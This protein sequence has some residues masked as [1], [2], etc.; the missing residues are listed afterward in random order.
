MDN[1]LRPSG[2][3]LLGDIPWGSHICQF[4]H[5]DADLLDLLVPWFQA[6][7]E[8]NECCMWVAS[9]PLSCAQA[10]SALRTVVPDLDARVRDGQ[11]LILPAEEWYLRDGRF[12]A[13]AVLD[14]W[15]AS[16]RDAQGRGYAG[17]RLSG[18]TFWLESPDWRD[19]TAYEAEV[20]AVISRNK[21]LALCTY[22]LEKCGA[23]EI[24]DVV[25]NHAVALIR[26]E[27][28]WEV[29]ES[30]ARRRALADAHESRAHYE[31][32][33][34]NMMDGFAYHELVY[35]D[36][37]RPVDYRFL[38]INDAFEHLTGLRR[39][40]VIGRRATEVLPGIE[41]DPA[42]W[43]GRYTHVALT[44]EP[45]RFEH[46]SAQLGRWY[47]V[48][49]YSP[50]PGHFAVTF[51]E[52]TERKQ[53][54]AA[55]RELN[56]AMERQVR[57]LEIANRELESFA[58][59]VSH[60]L[61]A[62]L[63]S[64]NGFCHIVLEDHGHELSQQA[65]GGLEHVRASSAHMAAL[66]D[67]LLQMSRLTRSP[68]TRTRVDASAVARDVAETLRRREPERTMTIAIQDNI[69]A[70]ADPVMLRIAI[71]NLLGNACKFT[72]PR[73]EAR[74]E[75]SS[76]TVD[77]E[78]VY[79]VRD[80]GVGFDM[81]DARQLFSPFQRLHGAGEFPGL[82]IGLATVQRVVQRHGGRVWAEA[83]VGR[84]AAFYFSLRPESHAPNGPATS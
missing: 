35:D 36:S 3:P 80:N 55:I 31:S 44:G 69:A 84:G 49:A 14:G 9:A 75:F 47:S 24:L 29:I 48:S 77:G 53:R 64:I 72:A 33:F 1:M 83:A 57:E 32:L 78:T 34:G 40:K 43:I 23:T 61:I 45:T 17:L 58:Y 13:C 22:A 74:I 37:G 73:A 11:I 8:N 59:S 2:I 15:M 26:R 16:L 12:N 28:D 68:L 38:E 30:Q 42:D 39:E 63:R 65:K 4:Y 19:F 82:G 25:K 71:D 46:C 62:P 52:I 60:D 27:G 21:V 56:Q 5:S 66:I 51:E 67:A 50:K 41:C 54:E 81:A 6:G 10:K 20:D 7:L 18:N 79:C 76:S 70:E